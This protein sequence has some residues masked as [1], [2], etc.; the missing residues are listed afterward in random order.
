MKQDT[1]LVAEQEEWGKVKQELESEDLKLAYYDDTLIPLLG[2]LN[3]KTVLDYGSGPGVLALALQKFG[4][5]V[6]VY[7]INQEMRESAGQK[8]GMENVYNSPQEIPKTVTFGEKD[9]RSFG[10]T[11]CPCLRN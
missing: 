9:A 8:I 6:K 1:K 4:A 11:H 2:D 7:D 10:D 5:D 3:G